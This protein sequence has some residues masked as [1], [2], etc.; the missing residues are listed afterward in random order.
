MRTCNSKARARTVT[1]DAHG[2]CLPRVRLSGKPVRRRPIPLYYPNPPCERGYPTTDG[3]NVATLYYRRDA[4]GCCLPRVV[5]A[6]GQLVL[7]RGK[8]VD[9]NG[10]PYQLG[11]P[12]YVHDT[13]AAKMS[14][15]H[16][17]HTHACMAKT[18]RWRSF[19]SAHHH[20][21]TPHWFSLSLSLALW[22]GVW[23]RLT[24]RFLLLFP[25]CVCVRVRVVCSVQ[26]YAARPAD[27]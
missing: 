14:P 10:M 20:H 8:W 16:F 7:N 2:C 4:Y 9:G 25:S 18:L 21:L 3:V 6:T 24:A 19:S 27:A 15:D 13:P 17:V 11:Q 26:M 1:F 5:L 12:E 22:R 23:L